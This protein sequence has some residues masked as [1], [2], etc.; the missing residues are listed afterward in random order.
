M[1]SGIF[2]NRRSPIKQLLFLVLLS[3]LLSGCAG[4][5]K[6]EQPSALDWVTLSAGQTI[7]QTFV[8]K[9]DGLAGV[10][11]YLSPQTTGNGVI[12]L[13]LRSGPQ[14]AEDLAVSSNTLAFEAVK[15]PGFYGFY[16]P[17]QAASNQKYYYAFLEV[18]GS[19]DILV[20]KA[21][22]DTYLNGALY[23]NGTSADAQA[24]FQ[25]SYSRRKAIL[26]LGLEAI[27]WGG[28]LAVGFFLFILPGWGLVSLLWPSWGKLTWPERLGLSAGASLA[29]YPLLLLWTGIVGLHL[30]AFYAWLAIAGRYEGS[31]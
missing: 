25:L 19:G 30:G 18:S 12:R 31:H 16:F 20:G 5:V 13:H 27:T 17:S 9:Y 23:Q 14:S 4:L 6:T 11:F 10:Y 8:A 24:A 21:A 28:I 3:L 26:G 1:I 15:A 22:G 7:G 2:S 29:L